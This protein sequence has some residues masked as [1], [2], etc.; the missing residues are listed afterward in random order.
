[1]SGQQRR[2]MSPA[3]AVFRETVQSPERM[4]AQVEQIASQLSLEKMPAARHD[5]RCIREGVNSYPREVFLRN[6]KRGLSDTPR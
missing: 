2:L 1:M 3:Y 5:G 4:D 6:P